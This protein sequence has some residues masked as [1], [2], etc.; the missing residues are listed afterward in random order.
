MP[1]PLD[2]LGSLRPPPRFAEARFETYRAESDRQREALHEA[3]AFTERVAE[4]PSLAER[5]HARLPGTGG[6]Q[7]P[8][9]L[10]LV[11]PAGTGKTHLMAAAFHALAPEVSCAFLHSGTFFR[12]AA[13]PQRLAAALAEEHRIRALLLDEVELDDAANEAR[14]SHFLK[15]LTARGVA[16]MATSNARPGAFLSRHVSGGGAHRR[17]L[18]DALAGRCE[19]VLVRGAD[20]RRQL[21]GDGPDGRGAVFVGPPAAARRALR[22]AHERAAEPKRWCSFAELRRASTE[23]AHARLVEQL[24][25]TERLSVAG[26]QV[27]DTD[28]ALR[29]LRLIDDLYTAEAA[30][31]LFFS[32]AAPPEDWFATEGNEGLRGGVAG[33]FKRT[34]SRLHELCAVRPVGGEDG[35]GRQQTADGRPSQRERPFAS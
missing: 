26:V 9:G 3:R 25:A 28:D 13:A 30:P 12:T 19:T 18:T 15:A 32:A 8:R 7:P 35:G 17:F 34:V 2:A 22:D 16:L 20:R 5:L 33:K 31:A 23:T 14:L 24:L 1:D 27:G 21:D 6:P 11:G 10:Y 29:L 4:A